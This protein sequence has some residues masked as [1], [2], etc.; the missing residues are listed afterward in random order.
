MCSGTGQFFIVCLDSQPILPLR[1]APLDCFPFTCILDIR[2]FNSHF[3]SVHMSLSIPSWESRKSQGDT[4]PWPYSCSSPGF[5]ISPS[6]LNKIYWKSLFTP[7]ST[8][9][10]LPPPFYE[11]CYCL[12]NN[13]VLVAKA[14]VYFP[15]LILFNFLEAL[16]IIDFL[17]LE[18]SCLLI[19]A[20]P[21]SFGFSL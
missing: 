20:T 13:V 19:S 17:F 14:N 10:K 5:I 9:T 12:E 8:P 7:R 1:D 6:F 18:N 4:F 16:R 21:Y 3:S 11:E 15:A 2:L